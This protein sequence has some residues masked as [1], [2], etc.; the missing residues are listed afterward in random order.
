MASNKNIYNR[1]V[2]LRN[3]LNSFLQK[4]TGNSTDYYNSLSQGQLIELKLALSDVNNVMTLKT[5]L[6]FLDWICDYFHLSKEDKSLEIDKI[7]KVKPNTNGYDIE[8]SS[9]INLVAEVKC[10]IP[11]NNGN[12]YGAAQYDS[13]LDDAVKLNRG[14]KSIKNTSDYFKF[15]GLIDIG[16]KTDSAISK[17]MTPATNIRTKDIARLKRHE[18]VKLLKPINDKSILKELSKEYI[19]IKKIRI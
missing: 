13:I 7:N 11:F 4:L 3:D 5:T 15:I 19:Y 17:L 16:E 9:S 14:K 8:I 18:V 10:I 12:Y 1:T 6:M 2:K